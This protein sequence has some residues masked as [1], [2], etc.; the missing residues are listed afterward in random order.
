M[1]TQLLKCVQNPETIDEE[2]DSI[3]ALLY[4]VDPN[5]LNETLGHLQSVINVYH[6]SVTNGK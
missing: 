4:V 1:L 6:R 5:N 3:G 2:F